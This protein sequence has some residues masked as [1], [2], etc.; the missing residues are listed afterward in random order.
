VPLPLDYLCRGDGGAPAGAPE[1]DATT[2]LTDTDY[3][4]NCAL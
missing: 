1:Y 2:R 3:F 4:A